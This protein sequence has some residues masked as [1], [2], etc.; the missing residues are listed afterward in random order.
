MMQDYNRFS[1]PETE[2]IKTEEIP[3]EMIELPE[4][5]A[6]GN[7]MSDDMEKSDVSRDWAKE[8]YEWISSLAAAVV[9]AFVINLF[10]F[11]LVQV[12]GQSMEPTLAHGERLIVRKAFYTPAQKDIVIVKSDVLQ[13]YIVKRIVALPGQTADFDAQL[14]LVV[15]NTV[16]S[17]PYIKQHQLSAGTLYDF[18][19]T[20][21]K[22][23]D[24]AQLQ[25]VRDEAEAYLKSGYSSMVFETRADGSVYVEGSRLVEDGVF[26]EGV[27]TYKQDCY[28]VLGDNRNHSSDSRNLGLVP[29][30]EIVGKSSFRLFPFD[31]MGMVE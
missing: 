12:D 2:Q 25:L 26:E 15:D 1:E 11:A 6:Y 7:D 28:F 13:K 23:G 4:D 18:P 30:E 17:E 9:L 31:K 16:L 19:I 10:F 22:K 3:E 20:V 27:T 14:N 29:E 8:A 21:P 5:D 24:V